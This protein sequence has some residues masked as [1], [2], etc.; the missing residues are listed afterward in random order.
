MVTLKTNRSTPR[1]VLKTEPLL[2]PPNALPNPAPRT[3]SRIKKI[4]TML[5][6]I[7]MMRIAGSHCAA[8]FF[9]RCSISPGDQGVLS[10]SW[11][12]N[13][14]CI[15]RRYIDGVSKMKYITLLQRLS[16]GFSRAVRFFMAVWTQHDEVARR[17][18]FKQVAGKVQRVQL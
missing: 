11:D 18:A 17:I 10:V 2:L 4:T 14:E 16:R 9:L 3:W 5:S 15:A 7:W 8:K 12:Y 13:I 6:M 1:R